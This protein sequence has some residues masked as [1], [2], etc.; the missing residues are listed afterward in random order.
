MLA[1]GDST[2]RR[3]N[4]IVRFQ[5]TVANDQLPEVLSQYRYYILPSIYEG[6]PKTLLEA[7][8]CGLVCLATRIPGVDEIITQEKDGYLISGTEPQDIR[9][10]LSRVEKLDYV[11]LS[12]NAVEI[13]NV[14][15]RCFFQFVIHF[16]FQERIH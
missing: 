11:R 2:S 5:G 13:L 12:Q 1:Q 14:G 7:M 16:L 4:V 3:K 6:M 10:A 9:E 15:I 8:A